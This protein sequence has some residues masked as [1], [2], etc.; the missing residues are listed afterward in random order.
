M[1]KRTEKVNFSWKKTKS[2]PGKKKVLFLNRCVIEE[3][4]LLVFVWKEISKVSLIC[5]ANYFF[6]YL[7]FSHLRGNYKSN[8]EHIF[9]KQE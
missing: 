5:K 4:G 8:R 2:S 3:Y 6:I 1:R 9:K 7:Q